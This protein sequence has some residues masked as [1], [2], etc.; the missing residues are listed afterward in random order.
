MSVPAGGGATLTFDTLVDTEDH[1]DYGFVQVSTDGGETYESVSCTGMNSDADPGAIALVQNNLPGYSGSSGGWITETCSLAAYA[2]QDVL[3]AFRYVTDSF[4]TEPGWWIDNVSV[5]GTMVSDGSTL[6]G[7]Q[8]MTQVN[9]V[10]VEDFTVQLV[11][12]EEAR[13][14]F[15]KVSRLR[16]DGDHDARAATR[17]RQNLRS[18]VHPNADVVAAIV[19]YDESTELISQYAPYT[20]TV[21]GVVQP[22]GS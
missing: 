2:G 1:W 5:G 11:S 21:N 10:D 9:P 13:G 18:L 6:A 15:V 7:W 22:G 19:M 17:G 12:Y 4:V 3:L 8:S 14:R 16:L 20:L